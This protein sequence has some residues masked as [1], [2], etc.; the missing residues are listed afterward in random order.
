[1]S[2]GVDSG[3]AAYLIKE[4]GY[5]CIGATMKLFHNENIGLTKD[6]TCC[7][8]TDTEDAKLVAHAV[9]IKHYTFNFSA[10]FRKQVMDKF[11]AA[12]ANGITPNPCIDCNR[13]LKFNRLLR[14]ADELGYDYIATGHYARI[15]QDPDTKRYLLKKAKDP[16]KDQSYVLYMLTQEQLARTIFPLG[17]LCK[18]EVRQIAADRGFINAEK[19]DSQDI[20]FV[21]DGKYADF[22]QEYTGQ[23]YKEGNFVDLQ[24][25]ILGRHKG[26]IHYT[27][28][29]RKGLGIAAGCP[30]Y[31][32][33]I[34]SH[35]N[36]ITLGQEQD[37][38]TTEVIAKDINLIA[39]ESITSPMRL[40]AKLRYHQNEQWA[41]VEQ[42]DSD[43]L[44]IRFDTPQRAAA[45]G[46]AVVLYND[47]IVVGGGTL[48]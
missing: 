31:V 14:R 40:K 37:L 41:T 8:L 25:N 18:N 26:L 28:G 3:V 16:A 36:A 9:G 46:Q 10:D 38:Y 13:Y 35:T 32:C 2:G 48:I 12:Y 5:R 17:N 21:P 45:R 30:L 42:T 6:K 11:C 4:Q 44:R 29:Q 1:M 22:I 34:D 7:S 39:V 33:G 24:G 20:C 15:E 23:K 47:D 43:T 27:I 19:H